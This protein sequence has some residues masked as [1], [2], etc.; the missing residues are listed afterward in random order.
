MSPLCHCLCFWGLLVCL[1]VFIVVAFVVFPA[2]TGITV[3][4]TRMA[5]PLMHPGCLGLRPCMLG[6]QS[7]KPR[8]CCCL[9]SCGRWHYFNRVTRDVC[10]TALVTWPF[11]SHK[12][13]LCLWRPPCQGSGRVCQSCGPISAA[14][15]ELPRAAGSATMVGEP[16]LQVTSLP[17][18]QFCLPCAFQ[19]TYLQMYRC[20]DLIGILMC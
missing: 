20:V 17:F 16:G 14:S 4:V 2:V 10:T 7:P 15:A 19:S 6:S 8:H 5:M 18:L 9:I 3:S 12:R 11:H 1:A 13:G